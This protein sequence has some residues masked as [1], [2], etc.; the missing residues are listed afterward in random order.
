[1]KTSGNEEKLMEHEGKLIKNEGQLMEHDKQ[2]NNK[3]NTNKQMKE[4]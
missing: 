2:L 1:M 4:N 3:R